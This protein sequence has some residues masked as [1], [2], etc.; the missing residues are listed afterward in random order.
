MASASAGGNRQSQKDKMMAARLKALGIERT[1][2]VCPLC[3]RTIRCYGPQSRYTHICP[4]GR[5]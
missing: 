5:Q 1:T 4:G 3:Y 2:Q